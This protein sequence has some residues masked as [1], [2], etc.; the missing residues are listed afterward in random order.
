[1]HPRVVCST[2][3]QG[4]LHFS[5]TEQA[6]DEGWAKFTLLPPSLCTHSSCER[7]HLNWAEGHLNPTPP[8]QTPCYEHRPTRKGRSQPEH[9]GTRTGSTVIFTYIYLFEAAE[10]QRVVVNTELQGEGQGGNM[11]AAEGGDWLLGRAA[12]ELCSNVGENTGLFRT[13]YETRQSS[14]DSR[15]S[16]PTPCTLLLLTAT[17]Y[18]K[19]VSKSIKVHF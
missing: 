17:F 3:Q 1:M 19:S 5:Y 2:W 8:L 12:K 6:A 9:K 13:E 16:C 11:P 15:T 4:S 18:S 7:L 14:E 10:M